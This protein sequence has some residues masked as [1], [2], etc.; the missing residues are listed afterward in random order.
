M[1]ANF[2]VKV[3]RTAVDRDFERSLISTNYP[4]AARYAGGEDWKP[5]GFAYPLPPT[6]YDPRRPPPEGVSRRS[7]PRPPST[8]GEEILCRRSVTGPRA[9]VPTGSGRPSGPRDL[10]GRARE[11]TSSAIR[12]SRRSVA[13]DS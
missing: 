3:G 8:S 11:E 9:P 6:A 7:G 1:G 10:G 13:R 12:A 5:G 4:R 2:Q